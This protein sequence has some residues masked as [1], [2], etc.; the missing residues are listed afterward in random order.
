MV[1]KWRK[2]KRPIIIENLKEIDSNKVHIFKTKRELNKWF[3]QE[4]NAKI[5]Y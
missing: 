4:F 5:N 1:V 3:E 2:N